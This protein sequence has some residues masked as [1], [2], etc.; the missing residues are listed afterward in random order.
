MLKIGA[1]GVQ[2]GS[3][4]V[5]SDECN[6]SDELKNVMSLQTLEDIGIDSKSRWFCL[7]KQ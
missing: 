5:A 6:A 4:F 7:V 2:M 1:S 3:R